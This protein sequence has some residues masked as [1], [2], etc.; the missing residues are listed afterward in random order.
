[1]PMEQMGMDARVA[2]P[3]TLN[4]WIGQRVRTWGSGV[5]KACSW[6][7]DRRKRLVVCGREGRFGRGR[8]A[9]AGGSSYDGRSASSELALC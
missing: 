2:Q 5:A 1:M 6:T 8:D 4:K 9:R 7:S 3:G